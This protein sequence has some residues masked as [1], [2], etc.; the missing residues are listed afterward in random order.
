MRARISKLILALQ[1]LSIGP[2]TNLSGHP[3]LRGYLS[4]PSLS[5]NKYLLSC[6]RVF[7]ILAKIFSV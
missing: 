2:E 7:V 5:T 1:S 3:A 6:L 4:D